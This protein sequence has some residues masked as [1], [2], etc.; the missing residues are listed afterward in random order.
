M[1]VAELDKD[2]R[3]SIRATFRTKASPPPAEFLKSPESFL[4]GWSHLEEVG[5]VYISQRKIIAVDVYL[6][7]LPPV[8]F[9]TSEEEDYFVQQFSIQGFKN[10]EF[11]NLPKSILILNRDFLALQFYTHEVG[12]ILFQYL[13]LVFTISFFVRIVTGP[14]ISPICREI[15]PFHSQY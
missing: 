8:P 7:Q 1:A 11:M 10:S 4:V 15:I 9:F 5:T 6:H 2:I 3:R 12:Y 14:G 13:R